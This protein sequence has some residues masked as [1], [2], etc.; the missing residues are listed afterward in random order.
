M[1]NTKVTID[2]DVES[3][4][5]EIA[6]RCKNGSWK[7]MRRV[8]DEAGGWERDQSLEFLLQIL[9]ELEKLKKTEVIQH[10]LFC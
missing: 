6:R 5:A 9:N 8:L 3:Y 10:D 1:P 7:E 4:P 2:D